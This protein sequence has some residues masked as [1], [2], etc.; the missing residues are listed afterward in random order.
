MKNI[1]FLL[2]YTIM[3][4]IFATTVCCNDD[5]LFLE[6]K[7]ATFFTTDNVFSTSAQVDQILLGI[8]SQIRNMWAN[9][10]SQQEYVNF[11]FRGTDLFDVT[12]Y[13]RGGSFSDYGIINPEHAT[14]RNI[15]AAFYQIV[16]KAN[17]AIYAADLPQISWASEQDKAYTLA[18]ARFFRAFA[19]RNLG[20][21][22]GG[23]P[24]VTEVVNAPRYDYVRTSRD[25]TYGFA[26]DELEAILNDL[27]ETTAQGGRIVR[28]AAQ[29]NLC[30][31]YLARGIQREADGKSSEAQADYAKS[32]TYA[33]AVIDGGTYSLMNERFG[34]RKDETSFS[35]NIYPSGVYTPD[36]NGIVGTIDFQTN[37]YWDLFQEDNV[38]YQD[39]NR[40]CIWAIQI[41]YT[42]YKNE[43]KKSRLRY[44]Q[45]YSPLVRDGA[46]GIIAGILEDAGGRPN[47][48][49]TMN[50]YV[51]D[52]IWKDKWGDD[53]RNS[54]AV[55]RRTFKGNV[56]ASP[57]YLIDIPWDVMYYRDAD[58][59]INQRN[60]NMCYPLSCK[61]YTDRYTGLDDGEVRQNLFR[62]DYVIR[63]SETIL[64]RAEAKQ[65]SGN[66]AGAAAD[67]NLL[68]SR[69]R[70]NY[71]V[72]AA[73]VDDEF[74]LIL[75]ERAR[76][77]IYEECRWNT[78][79]RMGGTV[80]VDRIKKYSFY[81]ETAQS[82]LTFNF[83]LWPV[84][85]TVIDINKDVP[86]EQNP[87]WKNR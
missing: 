37:H 41:D 57:Y 59:L 73:D 56:P 47:A 26:I 78:L 14:F 58:P 74:N 32:I 35:L 28:G 62:D 2:F 3:T 87:G 82:T 75:D 83:N 68:R 67:I 52:E 16:S 69:A 63:L 71:L 40:E 9:P 36:V 12:A 50:W 70:C 5:D 53:V 33:N 7:P 31:L 4:A 13:D 25:E 60:Q 11:R 61:I 17:L 29:H 24:L 80:A 1:K 15:Y 85:Q 8:Y 34:K 66:K 44:T 27:P 42:A 49:T 19:Y 18:Q 30:E 86:M 79:L 20:E 72:T 10:D 23:V 84:P 45:L 22:Y 55:F 64:L 76:E 81:Q 39:G 77:L 65:R 46:A 54:D 43:D 6:E 21:L 38:N 51:R 48:F